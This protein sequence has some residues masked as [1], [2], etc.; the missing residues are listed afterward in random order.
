MLRWQA[1]PSELP[2]R[3]HS[4]S[5][6]HTRAQGPAGAQ[7]QL[8]FVFASPSIAERV[9]VRALNGVEEWGPSDHCRIAIDLAD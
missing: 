3:A 2:E 6:Y 5:T 9:E 1:Q 7:R 8:D 4:V